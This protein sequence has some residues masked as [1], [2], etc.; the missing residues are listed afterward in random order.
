M[1]AITSLITN[2][3]VRN[4]WQECTREIFIDMLLPRFDKRY[5]EHEQNYL[6]IAGEQ[7]RALLGSQIGAILHYISKRNT[8][9]ETWSFKYG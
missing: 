9:L 2:P 8:F 4:L 1:N 7:D 5:I 3:M 6:M